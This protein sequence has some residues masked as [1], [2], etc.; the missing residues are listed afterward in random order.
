M[1]NIKIA[2]LEYDIVWENPQANFDLINQIL[3][4]VEADVFLLPEMFSTGFTMNPSQYAEEFCG[5]SF[6]F[7]QEKAIEKNAA[8]AGSVPTKISHQYFNR[9]YWTDPNETF[10]FYDKRH[11]FSLA[12]ENEEYTA[13]KD[14]K[15]IEFRGWK[16]MP[17]I[18]YD[19]RFPVWSRN[20][21]QYD[22]VFYLSNWPER[23]SYPWTQLLKARAIENLSY[24]IGVNRIGKDNNGIMHSG[25]S[26]VYDPLGFACEFF[27]PHE[28]IMIF[29][30]NKEILHKTREK[31]KFLEDKDDFSL[32]IP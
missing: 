10:A 16:F 18:C 2:L 17:Q 4:G 25:D 11:M 1:E 31:F 20:N 24:C 8:F 21:L 7:L 5:I 30:I 6:Q 13:G 32:I 14:R 3:L 12:K 28:H 29:E 9:L 23:R 19:L 26:M 22:V 15:L 27:Q